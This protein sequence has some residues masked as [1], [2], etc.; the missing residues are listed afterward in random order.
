MD[1]QEN[2]KTKEQQELEK[3]SNAINY[4]AKYIIINLSLGLIVIV[5]TTNFY[6]MI[7]ACIMIAAGIYLIIFREGLI[8]L[9]KRL[10]SLGYDEYFKRYG[11][12]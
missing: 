12:E 6:T 1:P 3:L 5:R 9:K 2:L 7:L 11:K 8:L 4:T 10:I